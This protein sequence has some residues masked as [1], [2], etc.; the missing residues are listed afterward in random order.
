[1]SSI[2]SYIVRIF[3][4]SLF[5]FIAVLTRAATASAAQ[6][7][8][9]W[10]DT[11]LNE[12]GCKLERRNGSRGTF[13]PV[14]KVKPN[15]TSYVDTSVVVGRTYCYRIRAYNAAGYSNTS[16]MCGTIRTDPYMPTVALTG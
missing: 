1:M 15:V 2:R 8:V 5:C 4:L 10:A 9:A 14:A 13:T 3:S 6:L 12:K 11:S 16:E 7:T